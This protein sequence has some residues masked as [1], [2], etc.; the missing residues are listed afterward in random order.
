MRDRQYLIQRGHTWYLRMAVPKDLQ[1]KISKTDRPQRHVVQTLRTR[2]IDVARKRRWEAK[3]AWEAQFKRL[4]MGLPLAGDLEA[5]ADP[6]DLYRRTLKAQEEQAAYLPTTVELVEIDKDAII[7][8]ELA[9]MGVSDTSELPDDYEVPETVQAQLDARDDLIPALDGRRVLRPE[10][11]ITVAKATEEFLDM[12]P[13]LAPETKRVYAARLGLFRLYFRGRRLADI[14][15]RDAAQFMKDVAQLSPN[16]GRRK[17]PSTWSALSSRYQVP[18]GAIGLSKATLQGF[19]SVLRL[20]W[21]WARSSGEVEAENPFSGIARVTIGR[22]SQERQPFDSDDLEALFD[23]PLP[24][25]EEL[26]AVSLVALYAGLRL[27]EILNLRWENVRTGPSGVCYLDITRAKTKAGVRQ[28]PLHPQLGWLLTR[29]R[30]EGSVWAVSSGV[31]TK[32][33][34]RFCNGRGVSDPCKVFHSFRHNFTASLAQTNAQEAFVAEIV[35]HSK[36]NLT[37]GRYNSKGIPLGQKFEIIQ[38]VDYPELADFFRRHPE[39]AGR[40]SG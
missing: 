15:R 2:D 9:R 32:W 6:G 21:E 25:R 18:A 31:F 37:F 17:L 23:D 28:V 22:A 26:W 39:Y 14:D 11:G 3:A 8:K 38:G 1:R 19:Q 36:A 4:A 7:A 16:W 35:G 5:S 29:R 12:N 40:N 34:G 33:F 13:G 24:K 27:G 30:E 10:Y 20:L